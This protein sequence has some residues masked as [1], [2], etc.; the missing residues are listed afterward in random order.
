M[1]E[2][3]AVISAHKAEALREFVLLHFASQTISNDLW[4]WLTKSNRLSK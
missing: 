1:R 2:V 3:P 4:G